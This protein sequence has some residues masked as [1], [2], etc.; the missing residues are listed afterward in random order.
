MNVN[1]MREILRREILDFRRQLCPKSRQTLGG[2]G[3]RLTLTGQLRHLPTKAIDWQVFFDLMLGNSEAANRLARVVLLSPE[4]EDNWASVPH[5]QKEDLNDFLAQLART[6]LGT[7]GNALRIIRQEPATFKKV[8]LSS[9][10]IA[11]PW[12]RSNARCRRQQTVVELPNLK[13]L[14]GFRKLSVVIVNTQD[15][16]ENDFE[17]NS[18]EVIADALRFGG[19]LVWLHGDPFQNMPDWLLD[20]VGNAP[21][22]D[23]R[24]RWEHAGEAVLLSPACKSSDDV[25]W[26][27]QRVSLHQKRGGDEDNEKFHPINEAIAD[28]RSLRGGLLSCEARTMAKLLRRLCT[29]RQWV[30]SPNRSPEFLK[31]LREAVNLA[32]MKLLCLA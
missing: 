28:E 4:I 15:E 12:V 31:L 6:S 32:D 5:N 27:W 8:L 3:S 11:F 13:A 25:G 14:N 23:E 19:Y 10:P 2:L 7:L 9:P 16:F 29:R 21:D 1:F 30:F 22:P 20:V 24:E 26:R 17:D 18:Q